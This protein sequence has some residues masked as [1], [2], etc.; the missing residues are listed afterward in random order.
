MP[1]PARPAGAET[2]LR[3]SVPA[4]A[5]GLSLLDYLCK[6]FRYQERAAWQ[7]LI[8]QGRLT[9]NGQP[10]QPQR[11]LLARDLVAY[12]VVLKEPPV[13]TAIAILHQEE[14]FL[15]ASKP[16][17]L[18]SHADGTF[19]RNTFIALLNQRLDPRTPAKLVHRLDRETSGLMVAALKK[20]SHQSLTR[21]FESHAVAKTYLA[22]VEGQPAQDAF[23]VQGLLGRDPQSAV[24][25]RHALLAPGSPGSES[26]KASRTLFEV[27]QRFAGR[28][29]LACRPLTGRTNQIRVHLASIGL[30][31]TGDKLYGRSDEQFLNFVRHVKAGGDPMACPGLPCPR[32]LLHAW[33]LEFNHPTQ[34]QRLQF[35]APLPAD[36]SA[37]L[38][39][40]QR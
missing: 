2:E 36:F 8:Q 25:I 37:F 14:G 29:L 5:A 16:G 20:E 3:S 6:R 4:A 31:I 13:D 18:P 39:S 23:E 1:S 19:I 24:S 38:A 22:L 17:G 11:R 30:P 40:L 35:E 15:V 9:V 12:K 26:A 21:Q 32:Q 7:A 34:G 33:Q 10:C 28:A 27:R